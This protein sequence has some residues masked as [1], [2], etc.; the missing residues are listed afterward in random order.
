L[1]GTSFEI[2]EQRSETHITPS[3]V[4]QPFT[5]IAARRSDG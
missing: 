4:A 3:G 1:L 5:W 2:V